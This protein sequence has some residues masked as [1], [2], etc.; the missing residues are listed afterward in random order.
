AP[1]EPMARSLLKRLRYSELRSRNRVAISTSL[2]E[3]AMNVLVSPSGASPEALPRTR[4][5]E[6]A[7]PL[8][9]PRISVVVPTRARPEALRCCI[10]ALLEQNIEDRAAYE[11]VVVDDGHA[12]ETRLAVEAM[13]P[14]DGVPALRYF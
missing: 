4:E 14:A 3:V 2:P 13:K 11:I 9:V 6:V 1:V 7:R 8:P 12:E 5:R 10:A